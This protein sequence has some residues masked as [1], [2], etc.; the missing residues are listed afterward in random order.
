MQGDMDVVPPILA[1]GLGHG[2]W[3]RVDYYFRSTKGKIVSYFCIVYYVIA[4]YVKI[5]ISNFH[6]YLCSGSH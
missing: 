1:P 5:I 3:T 6:I 2:R 4:I